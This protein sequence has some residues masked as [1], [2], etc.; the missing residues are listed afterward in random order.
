MKP[1]FALSAVP[2]LLACGAAQFDA[3]G[4]DEDGAESQEIVG[5]T[6]QPTG[7][8]AVGSLFGYS[9]APHVRTHI[10]GAVLV[11]QRIAITAAHCV[12]RQP[13]DNGPFDLTFGKLQHVRLADGRNVA[14]P[15]GKLYRVSDVILH[16]DFQAGTG[17]IAVLRLAEPVLDRPAAGL[18]AAPFGC[19]NTRLVGYGRTTAGAANGITNTGYT[20]ERKSLASCVYKKEGNWVFSSESGGTACFGDSGSGLMVQGQNT[21]VGLVKDGVG[22]S[23]SCATAQDTRYTHVAPYIDWIRSKFPA[24]IATPTQT[25]PPRPPCGI[26]PGGHALSRGEQVT[27]CEGK[28]IRLVYQAEGN[29]VL[30][31]GWKPLWWTFAG[32]QNSTSL[33]MQGDG[34]LVLYSGA[35]PLWH[36]QT[37]GNPGG[38]MAVQPDCN[39][40]VY[41]AAGQPKWASGTTCFHLPAL[42][43]PGQQL[44]AGQALHNANGRAMLIYQGD[45][46]LVLYGRTRAL[47]HTQ[48]HG[49]APGIA[50]MQGD[51]N[52]VVYDAGGGVRFNAA[53]NGRP[54][55]FLRLQTDCRL[56][57]YTFDNQLVKWLYAGGC[58]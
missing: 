44:V 58:D 48:T 18:A 46:N 42:L 56:G 1:L 35:T 23:V 10:C 31:Q 22:G 19:G 4:V 55:N 29:V 38:F 53:T 15:T 17:D 37:H 14:K 36:S 16:P 33:A 43:G 6:S 40:V 51:G 45:G 2:L 9:D 49:T 20:Y 21:V 8:D 50:V 41:N 27:D 28:G 57:V 52:F 12:D 25:P 26:L 24:T 30:Y 39:L 3:A 54:G 13:F 11:H 32:A 5:G 34:N 7:Y 47:W